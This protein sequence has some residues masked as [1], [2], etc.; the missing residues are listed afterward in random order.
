MPAEAA[1]DSARHEAQAVPPAALELGR[2]VIRT[3]RLVR[4]VQFQSP[5]VRHLIDR[6]RNSVEELKPL[7]REVA[8]I[9]ESSGDLARTAA[10]TA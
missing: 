3:S 5:V 7:E 10:A 9:Q 6:L 8:R 1:G 4:A 2:L